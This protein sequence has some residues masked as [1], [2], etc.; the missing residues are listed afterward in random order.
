MQNADSL[1]HEIRGIMET[2]R[3]DCR[4]AM[5]ATRPPEPPQP[6]ITEFVEGQKAFHLHDPYSFDTVAI[7]AVYGA[8]TVQR[9]VRDRRIRFLQ[10]AG[11]IL[12]HLIAKGEE[13]L[14]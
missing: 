13:R 7:R 4:E 9:C 12:D 8:F 5:E 6:I 11:A 14:G 1:G 10:R 2:V 3:S